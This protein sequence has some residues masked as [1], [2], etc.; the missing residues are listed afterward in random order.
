MWFHTLLIMLMNKLEIEN[1]TLELAKSEVEKLNQKKGYSLYIYYVEYVLENGVNILRI[2]C[3]SDTDISIDMVTELNETISE[4][5]DILDYIKDEYYLEVSSAGIEKE[6]RT[7][8]AINKALGQYIYIKTYEKVDGHKE[9]Y[10]YLESFENDNIKI[11]Y[12]VKNIQ[13]Y[14]EINKKQIALIRLAIKF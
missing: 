9:F 10:G 1:K 13:K 8:D 14:S 3:D 12:L 6:L 7:D 4:K 5:L 11:K 2:I